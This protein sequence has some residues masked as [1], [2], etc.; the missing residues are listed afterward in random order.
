MLC[1]QR[2]EPETARFRDLST[3]LPHQQL[4]V[5]S[6]GNKGGVVQRLWVEYIGNGATQERH[7]SQLYCFADLLAMTS[8]AT[9]GRLQNVIEYCIKVLKQNPAGQLESNNLATVWRKIT[10]NDMQKVCSDF[11]VE[12][13]SVL[14]GL[15]NWWASCF[16][17]SWWHLSFSTYRVPFI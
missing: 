13:C 6:Y 8:L 3:R 11:Q 16:V 14:V 17:I 4:P 12:W 7:I 9:S 5:R 15:T 2:Y 1:R 10:T